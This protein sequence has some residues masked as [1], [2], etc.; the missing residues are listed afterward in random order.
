MKRGI[1]L[2]AG[3]L[4]LLVASAGFAA[5]TLLPQRVIYVGHRE[6]E[7][8]PFLKE[9]FT[10]VES[11]SREKFQPS[12]AK[13]FD[14]VVLDW[15]QYMREQPGGGRI[16]AWDEQAPLGKREEWSKSTVLLG[17]AGLNLAVSWKLKGGSGCTCL[18]PV[19]YKLRDHEIFKGPMPVNMATV[20][21][22]TP[23]GFKA[24]IKTDTVEVVP[25][26]NGIQKYN[27]VIHDNSPGWA[28]HYFEF[29]DM[30]E[31]EIFS[32]GVNEQNPESGAYWRQGNLLHFGFEQSPTKLNETGRAMLVNGIAYISRFS[33]DRPIDVTAS[34][35]ARERIGI[36]RRRAKN[37]ILNEDSKLEWLTNN[38]AA[39][40]LAKFN[41]HDRAAAK[42]WVLE[43]SQWLHPGK[44][45]FLEIDEEA[46]SLG[47]PFD[48]PD[49]VP[50]TIAALNNEQTITNAAILLS[51]YVDWGTVTKDK[52]SEFAKRLG[53][54]EGLPEQW[55]AGWHPNKGIIMPEVVKWWRENGNYVFYSELGGYKWYLDPL[56]KKRGVPTKELRGAKRADL[57]S[58]LQITN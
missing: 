48:A 51:R 50:K 33:E 6:G 30:P 22:P 57:N 25:L 41:W 55:P 13:D 28:T 47:T 19:A 17:S 38:Y 27:T 40:T 12:Q 9:H 39:A 31:V 11:V 4:G 8:V 54:P 36:S 44:D 42:A 16:N 32:G 21:I 1:G 10:K 35:F 5:D 49:F 23:D 34:V 24:D 26:I 15:P 43:N 58:K 20:T 14:V 18:A 53:F 52:E 3:T 7:Y 46:R 37:L 2:I 45:N 56:A 29:T